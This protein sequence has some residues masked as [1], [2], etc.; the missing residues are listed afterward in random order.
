M[1]IAAAAI[2][3]GCNR[4]HGRDRAAAVPATAA[5]GRGWHGSHPGRTRL[6]RAARVRRVTAT[7]AE[8]SQA[9]LERPSHAV[10]RTASI[11]RASSCLGMNPTNFWTS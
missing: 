7:Q 5:A 2:S 4:G 9:R 11:L 10:Y 8:T 6:A 3:H 1:G